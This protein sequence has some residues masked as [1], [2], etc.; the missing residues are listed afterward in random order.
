MA[1]SREQ[2]ASLNLLSKKNGESFPEWPNAIATIQYVFNN[3][4]HASIKSTP[5]KLLLGYDQRNHSDSKLVEFLTKLHKAEFSLSEERESSRQVA[6]DA[7]N[8]VKEYNKVYYDKRHKIPSAYNAGDFVLVRDTTVKPG[9][10]KKIKPV[11]KGP[12]LVD[13]VLEKNRFVIKDI[14]GFN[15]VSRPYNSILSPDR[16]KPWIRPATP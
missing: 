14:P 13:R 12:Y 8:K 9:E 4:F 10:D 16:L 5:S 6:L 15:R 11:Y 7:T 3:T 1:W 2:T